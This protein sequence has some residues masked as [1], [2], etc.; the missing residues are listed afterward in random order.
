MD[1]ICVPPAYSPIG[2]ASDGAQ[3]FVNQDGLG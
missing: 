1:S 2:Y 3:W